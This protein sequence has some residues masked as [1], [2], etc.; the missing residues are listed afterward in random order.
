MLDQGVQNYMFIRKINYIWFLNLVIFVAV[1]F[2]GIKQAGMGA[3]ILVLEKKLEQ[4]NASKRELSEAIFNQN[5]ESK[6]TN[7]EELGFI[8]PSSV[9]YFNSI[10]SVASV[11]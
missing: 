7:V 5:T 1:V 4:T 11:Q 2:F 8:K 10:D 3:D 9:I 6:L